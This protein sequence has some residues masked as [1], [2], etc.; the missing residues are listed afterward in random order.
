MLHAMKYLVLFY[1]FEFSVVVLELDVAISFA[2][3]SLWCARHLVIVFAETECTWLA[4]RR[5]V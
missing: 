3:I 4:A 2:F 1:V 5:F